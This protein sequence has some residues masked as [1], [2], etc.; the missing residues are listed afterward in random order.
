[1]KDVKSQH[2]QRQIP[3]FFVVVCF[4]YVNLWS[5]LKALTGLFDLTINQL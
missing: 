2:L 4:M 3:E 1:M 5:Q